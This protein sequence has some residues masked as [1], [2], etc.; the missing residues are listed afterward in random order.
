MAGTQYTGKAGH[1]ATM[2]EFCLRGYNA[3]MPEIDKGDDVFVVNDGT[4]A[5][6]RL[7]VKTSLGHRQRISTRYQFRV[8]EASIQN[9][10][11]PELHFVFVMRKHEVWAFLMMDRS[12]L[13]NYVRNNNA[14]TLAGDYRQISITVHDDGRVMCSGVDLRNHIGDWNA[15]P[16]L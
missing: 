14:G 15:W 4:G 5:M 11:M 6:W 10:Q 3:S 2:G 8:K 12:V 1:L 16:G 13:R 9:S 7:Q